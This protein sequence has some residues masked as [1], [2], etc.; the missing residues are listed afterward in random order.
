M[1]WAIL[2]CIY[3]PA[4]VVC[5]FNGAPL[6]ACETMIP[7]HQPFTQQEL[8]TASNLYEVLADPDPVSQ[9]SYLVTVASKNSSFKGFLVEARSESNAPVG[10]WDLTKAQGKAQT[11]DCSGS[12]ASAV[13]A[14]EETAPRTT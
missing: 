11:L 4:A 8:A 13:I 5:H 14:S 9:G 2:L 6:E 12:P 7:Q 10:T 1:K 3:F